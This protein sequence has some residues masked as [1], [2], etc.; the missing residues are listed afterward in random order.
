MHGPKAQPS[1]LCT[2]RHTARLAVCG[3]GSR[4][5]REAEL[6]AGWLLEDS[7]CPWHMGAARHTFIQGCRLLFLEGVGCSL[8]EG[9]VALRKQCSAGED[10]Q[11]GRVYGD[12]MS[13]QTP[14]PT[15]LTF[16]V[17]LHRI[18]PG[19]GEPC[20]CSVSVSNGGRRES[21]CALERWGG[22]ALPVSW[23]EAWRS[24]WLSPL[25]RP[26]SG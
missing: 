23:P 2:P 4:A 5:R 17:I 12:Q 26:R 3:A 7:S 13:A 9:Q 18:L 15:S 11:G 25:V 1:S 10:R 14:A 8:H 20:L 19:T 16:Q 21:R 24:A 22:K 6:G